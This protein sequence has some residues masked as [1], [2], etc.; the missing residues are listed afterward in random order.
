MAIT[1]EAAFRVSLFLTCRH[2]SNK[3]AVCDGSAD[4]RDHA[5]QFSFENTVEVLRSAIAHDA[6]PI[7][8]LGKDAYFA[9]AFVLA[10][11]NQAVRSCTA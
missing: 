11:C 8:Q 6:V 9:A 7:C 3:L 5:S 10:A 1:S 2:A 4:H